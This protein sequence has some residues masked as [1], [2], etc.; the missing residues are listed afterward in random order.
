MAI[1]KVEVIIGTEE[2]V[3]KEFKEKFGVELSKIKLGFLTFS[4]E[5]QLADFRNIYTALRI[6][7]DK[8]TINLFRREWRKSFVPAGVNPAL[9]YILCQL[10]DIKAEDIVLDPFC[11]GGTIP[12]TASIYFHAQKVIASDISGKAIDISME[13]FE[14][15]KIPQSAF[16]CFRGNVSQLKFPDNYVD[17]IITNMPFGIRTGN[18]DENIKIYNIFI[19]KSEKILKPG[20]QMV[21][22]T[23]EKSLFLNSL[24]GSR[25]NL[26]DHFM[27]RQG[28]LTPWIFVITKSTRTIRENDKMPAFTQ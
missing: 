16:M 25:L 26:K 27:I 7:D 19:K 14:S 11:G 13:N 24:S 12:I 17:K 10:A 8:K 9:A 28:G 20:G 2:V 6:S 15:A 3:K 21:V 23:Q 22:L 1:F 18:H 4:S 5:N